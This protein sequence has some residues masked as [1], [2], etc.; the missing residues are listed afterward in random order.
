MVVI[1][2]TAYCVRRGPVLS[3]PRDF[4]RPLRRL[5]VPFDFLRFLAVERR[6]PVN[7]DAVLR[8]EVRDERIT[9]RLYTVGG[10]PRSPVPAS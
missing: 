2:V 3:P 9:A 10:T 5:H 1:Q 7:V 4:L 8:E 6:G